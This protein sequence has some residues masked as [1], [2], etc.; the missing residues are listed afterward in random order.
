MNL[1]KNNIKRYILRRYSIDELESIFNQKL[2]N[3]SRNFKHYAN[4]SSNK[5]MVIVVSSITEEILVQLTD[6]W[7][8]DS[9]IPEEGLYKFIQEIFG[10]RIIKKYDE[11]TNMNLQEQI[12]RMKS[13]MGLIIEEEQ[14]VYESKPIVFVGTA[15]A[16]KST[17]SKVL[18]EKLQIPRIDLDEMEGSEEYENLC[19]GEKG[20]EVSITRTDDGN[21]YGTTN[22]EYRR[23]VLTKIL[24]KYGNTKVVIDVGGNSSTENPDLLVNLPNVFAIG[25]PPS[26]EDDAPYI[27]L[28]R[29][30]KIKR[31]KDQVE[32]QQKTKGK[33]DDNLIK[34]IEDQ[35]NES[36]ESTQLS[37]N[38]IREFYRGKQGINIFNKDGSNKTTEELVDEIITKLT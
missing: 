33:V 1:Q 13:M 16:G 31:L 24:E 11:L 7:V 35:E 12:S 38:N 2:N 34:A 21:Q 14:K 17:T 37:I 8:E 36:N 6:G 29:Q 9:P 20:V 23:C 10:E 19:K 3:Q 25:L 26:E 32:K 5:F 22:K 28:L 4:M 27:E 15:G 18:A 30:R